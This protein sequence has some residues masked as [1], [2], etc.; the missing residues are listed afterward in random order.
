MESAA[1]YCLH[2]IWL[3]FLS[4]F[5]VIS[6]VNCVISISLE[7]IK[8]L[9]LM[10]HLCKLISH[11]IFRLH[12]FWEFFQKSLLIILFSLLFFC[13]SLFMPFDYFHLIFNV[14]ILFFQVW[15]CAK[16]ISIPKYL[17]RALWLTNSLHIEITLLFIVTWTLP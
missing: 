9:E 16:T 3:T 6:I 2:Y 7:I 1:L 5:L 4:H 11:F 13:L 8:S 17:G 14:Y 15:I 10:L 12:E